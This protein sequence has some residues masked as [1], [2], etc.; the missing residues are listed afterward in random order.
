VDELTIQTLIKAQYSGALDQSST[1]INLVMQT[2]AVLV[3]GIV[4]WRASNA[5]HRKK[6]KER[7]QN[8]YFET[9]Y[10]RHWRKK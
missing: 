8:N 10:S 3:G 7:Q 9:P 1:Y 5:I 2:V 6:Q 4:M